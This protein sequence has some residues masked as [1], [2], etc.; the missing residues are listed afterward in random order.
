[1]AKQDG[2]KNFEFP[3][4]ISDW[5]GYFSSFDKTNI[6]ENL[7]VRGSQNVYKKL[8][9]TIAVREGQKRLGS[10]DATL[11]PISS[12][13]VWNTSWGALYTLLVSN[14]NLYVVIDN[15]WYSLL[16]GLTK[17]R[18]VF[19]NWWDNTLKKDDCL[20]VNGT[21]DM[22]MWSGGYTTILSSTAN[23]L[24]KNDSTSWQQAGFTS[25]TFTTMG[26]ATTQ[27]DITN[28]AGTTFRYTWDGTGT[29]PL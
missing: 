11:S 2:A 9:G 1:M 26:S 23:T 17:T 27:F 29:D 8:S 24:T 18:Y 22:F 7:M 13:F 16:S 25:T 3:T 21:D 15:V 19:D 4:M 12:E 5:G 10:I 14:S 6:A 28:P 20:F